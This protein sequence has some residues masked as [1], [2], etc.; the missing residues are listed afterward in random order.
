MVSPGC[1]IA[2]LA[3]LLTEGRTNPFVVLKAPKT[4]LRPVETTLD[5]PIPNPGIQAKA[6][7]AVKPSKRGSPPSSLIAFRS[8]GNAAQPIGATMEISLA[9]R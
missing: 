4:L 9:P 1:I 5:A 3:T 8:L 6:S 7:A 2:L